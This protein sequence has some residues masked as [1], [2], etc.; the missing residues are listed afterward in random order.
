M[1]TKPS[2]MFTSDAELSATL[3][4]NAIDFNELRKSRYDKLSRYYDGDHDILY[5]NSYGD[6]FS[7]VINHAQGITDF[8]VGYLLGNEVEYQ[9]RQGSEGLLD[10]VLEEYREQEIGTLDVELGEDLSIF[11]RA[12]ELIYLDG[13]NVRSAVIDPRSAV[14]VYDTSV[15][16]NKRF[17]VIYEIEKDPVNRE[18]IVKATVYDEVNQYEYNN[19]VLG[20]GV[21]HNFE[22]IPVVEYHNNKR[23]TG[24]FECVVGLI[25]GYNILQSIRV[26][27]KEQLMDAILVAYGMDLDNTDVEQLK[28]YKTLSRVPSDARLEYLVKA[29]NEADTDVL[30]Q[31]IED[32]IHKISK[33]PNLTDRAF[34][35]NIS[36]VALAYKQ[37]GFQQNVNKKEKYMKKGFNER[38]TIYGSYQ[39]M[40]TD[41]KAEMIDIV[42][43]HGLP[44]NDLE[45]SSMIN[46]LRGQVSQETLISQ[47]SFVNDASEEIEAIESKQDNQNF[48]TEEAL[49]GIDRGLED[50]VTKKKESILQKLGNIFQ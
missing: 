37:L 28:K 10:R 33:V 43:K 47:L 39:L 17:A 49:D 31:V 45:I 11:G 29:L 46:N 13:N 22:Q 41:I 5:D 38:C 40:G 35:G 25:D 20:E 42:F 32:D 4:S 7:M 36:G 44:K 48:G 26:S 50:N 14:C 2:D 24:D 15:K 12:Y 6:K 34:G 19:G 27:D 8:Y 23:C 3:V 21:P 9:E 18:K 1:V 30:R 16:H